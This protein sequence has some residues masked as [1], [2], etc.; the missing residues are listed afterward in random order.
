[1]NFSRLLDIMKNECGITNL[2]DI[3]RELGVSP[4]SVSN[5]KARDKIP[6]KYV[7]EIQNRYVSSST[8][9]ELSG[10]PTNGGAPRTQHPEGVKR[11]SRQRRGTQNREIHHPT[12]SSE[13]APTATYLSYNLEED[14]ISLSDILL[15]LAKNLK[16]LILTPTVICIIAIIQVLFI[17]QPVYVATAKILPTGGSN[18]ASELRG[19]ATQ[20]GVSIPGQTETDISSSD[21]YPE[22]IKSRMFARVLLERK[23]DTEKFG[24][25]KTLLSILTSGSGEPEVGPD[26]L[27]KM[28]T[29]AVGSMISIEKDPGTSVFT[30]KVEGFEPQ[31]VADLATVVVEELDKL[32]RQ[33][34]SQKVLEKKVF[35]EGRIKDSQVELEA[36]EERLRDFRE[37]NRQIGNSPALLL[38]QERL[39]RDMEV[40]TGIFITLKQQYELVKIEEVQESAM[41]QFLDPPEAPLFRD[42]PKRRLTVILAGFLGIGLGIGAAFIREYFSKRNDEDKNKMSQVSNLIRRNF[43]GFIPSRRKT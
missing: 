30:V 5:W 10:D 3:A 19:L 29:G 18:P 1:M 12:E 36:A 9:S 33:F 32:Q 39:M 14:T 43:E 38:G 17:A 28:A 24:P 11:R 40:Q 22:I 8:Q 6:Y 31:F 27:I 25:Q 13:S 34:K 41:V 7:L 20:F 37:S 35:I 16:L 15:V 21:I 42:R 26:T 4:Q 2:A 23:F